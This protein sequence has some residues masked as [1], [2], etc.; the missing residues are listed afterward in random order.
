MSDRGRAGL[1]GRKLSKGRR[2]A[3]RTVAP[4]VA[5]AACTAGFGSGV[6][7]AHN[8]GEGFTQV[9]NDGAGSCWDRRSFM[10]H[11]SQ[12]FGYDLDANVGVAM[13]KP[14]CATGDQMVAG[15]AKARV[16]LMKSSSVCA[17]FGWQT[18]QNAHT[19]WTVGAAYDT[20]GSWQNY[21]LL[22][23][24]G[25]KDWGGTWRYYYDFASPV[26]GFS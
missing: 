23:D 21:F 9:Y 10:R 8:L 5:V 7:L 24:H 17:G 12:N 25:F 15:G 18:M 16:D 26:H 19:S 13:R 20:C 14:F 3:R 22:G 11:P 1:K 6:A 4:V 2:L